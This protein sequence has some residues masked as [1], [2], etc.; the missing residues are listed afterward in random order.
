MEK[1]ER[2]LKPIKSEVSMSVNYSSI[3]SK[4]WAITWKYK[5]LWVFGFL[6]MLGGGGAGWNGSGNFR[7]SYNVSP[8]EVDR[9]N[10]PPAW[11]SFFDQLFQINLNTWITIIVGVFCCL[12]LLFVI[13]WV[14][15][16]LGRGGLIGGIVKADT[17]GSI[18]LREAWGMGRRYFWR[19]LVL[20]LL[21]FVAGLALVLVILLPGAIL[22]V[23]T[24]GLGF[25]PLCCGAFV[26]GVGINLWFTL[27]DYAVVVENQKAG[28]AIGRAWNLLRDHIGPAIIF[29]LILAAASLCVGFVLLILVAPAG[30]VIF[31]SLLPIISQTGTLNVALLVIGLILLVLFMLASVVVNSVYTVWE[32]GVWTFAY[33]AFIGSQTPATSI[34]VNPPPAPLSSL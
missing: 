3:F 9:S 21:K 33:Q 16:I 2:R 17:A 22:G 25:I 26:I 14:L 5:I 1:W 7:T 6:A 12:F 4:A 29:Y 15:S 20:R 24:C 18:T 19:L 27:M 31:L 34:T 8:A 10:L 11:K 23:L 32:A 30:V 13:L 28:E